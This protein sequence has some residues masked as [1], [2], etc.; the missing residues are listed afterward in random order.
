MNSCVLS[1]DKW[2]QSEQSI[3]V[4]MSEKVRLVSCGTD[5]YSVHS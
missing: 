5:L 3:W 4:L 1:L 2:C